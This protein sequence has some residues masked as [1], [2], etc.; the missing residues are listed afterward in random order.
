MTLQT[1]EQGVSVRLID[2]GEVQAVGDVA[3]RI[4]FGLVTRSDYPLIETIWC[5]CDIC[6]GSSFLHEPV[7]QHFQ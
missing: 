4:G 7:E 5:L 1:D 6:K 2:W 3:D